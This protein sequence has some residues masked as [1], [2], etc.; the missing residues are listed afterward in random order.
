MV[1]ERCQEELNPLQELLVILSQLVRFV[2][3]S[4]E[5]YRTDLSILVD[6]QPYPII[7]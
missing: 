4:T 7:K 3:N 1:S 5:E 6:S 2:H